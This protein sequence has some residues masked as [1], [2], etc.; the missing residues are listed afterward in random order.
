[1]RSRY[2]T[3]PYGGSRPAASARPAS[4]ARRRS[5]PV[6]AR[7]QHLDAGGDAASAARR[8]TVSL[9]RC[10]PSEP[11]VTSR[12]GRRRVQAEAP[13]AA[14][15]RRGRGRAWL[16][17]RRSGMPIDPAAWARAAACR[18]RSTATCRVSRAPSRLATPGPGVL[19][20]HDDRHADAGGRR[21]RPG[22]ADVA[23]EADDDVRAGLLD[24]RSAARTAAVEAARQPQQVGA[25]PARQRHPRDGQQGVAAARA[26]AG[27][28][29]PPRCRAR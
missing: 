2:S 27:T 16:I 17:S 11:P 6:P 5:L 25:G 24:R 15:S 26:P 10:A 7:V 23:A 19:L 22:R 13:R 12:V 1:M 29:G 21:G 3:H 9:S 4:R 18:G 8:R 20:V 14:S 28:P